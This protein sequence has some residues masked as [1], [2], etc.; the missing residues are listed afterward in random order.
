MKNYNIIK[1][2][3]ISE[4]MEKIA[5]GY[6]PSIP[7]ANRAPIIREAPEPIV[8]N[9]F[10]KTKIERGE[11][12]REAQLFEN[13]INPL[14][15]DDRPIRADQILRDAALPVT[16]RNPLG[17]TPKARGEA[18]PVGPAQK[19]TLDNMDDIIQQASLPSPQYVQ[20]MMSQ[21]KDPV[22]PANASYAVNPSLGNT[23]APARAI[24]VGPVA[25]PV[26]PVK[27]SPNFN[28]IFKQQNASSFDPNSAMD[29][30]KMQKLKA[31]YGA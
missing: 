4:L 5:V 30:A 6:F 13:Q 11:A 29:R 18:P 25:A 27:V 23:G 17:K 21:G 19:V 8:P 20:K 10:G 14:F 26:A 12:P 1:A 16:P 7:N 28:A 9:I 22:V 15:G 2:A 3:A 31:R 24:P